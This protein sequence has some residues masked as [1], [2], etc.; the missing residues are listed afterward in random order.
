MYLLQM[1]LLRVAKLANC[2][3]INLRYVLLLPPPPGA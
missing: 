3:F 2:W 1:L